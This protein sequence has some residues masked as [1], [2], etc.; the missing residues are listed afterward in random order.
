[1]SEVVSPGN[2]L[3][4]R[5]QSHI[6]QNPSF[7]LQSLKNVSFEDRPV[8]KLRDEHDVRVHIE[9]TGICGS[10]VHYW[11]RGRI[12]DFVLD[13]PIVL[14]HESAGTIAEVGSKVKN[15]KI[16]DRVAIEPGVPCR[17]CD[18][19]REGSYNLC[20]DTVF[21]ATPPHDGTL[22]K[23]YIVASDYV[24]P[25]PDHMTAE[26]GALVE[27]V[28]VAVQIGKVADLRA[29]Q[30]VLVFGCGPIGVLCQAVAKAAG[31]SKVIGVDISESRAKFAEDFAADGVFVN[32]KKPVEGVDPV[33]AARAVG[34]EIV[35]RYGLGEGADVV[36][37]CTGAE[38]CIQAGIFAAKKGGTFVQAGMGRENVLFPITTA[39]I[40]ALTIKGSIRYS[41]GCYPQAVQLIASG[42]IKPSKLITHRYKFT[43]AENAFEVVRQAQE[44]TLKVII[45]GVPK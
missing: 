43:E 35:V 8:P 5:T 26:E 37:E 12:G 2:G 22:Q 28:A 42:K 6:S 7:V 39:C 27:P 40:R 32:N 4:P 25:I 17:R 31:A 18:Y 44:N 3:Q 9:Q 38:P 20:A 45:E 23:Y 24:Y 15:I 16:G 21:A 29:G 1:M 11:Q 19:C 10:D 34:E 41:T 14:G 36:L 33:D 30:T 13:S